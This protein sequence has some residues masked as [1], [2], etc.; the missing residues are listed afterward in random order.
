MPDEIIQGETIEPQVQEPELD[1]AEMNPED[2]DSLL[3]EE[4]TIQPE[5]EKSTEPDVE[6]KEDDQGKAEPGQTEPEIKESEPVKE[7]EK[8]PDQPVKLDKNGNPITGDPLKDTQAELTRSKQE[9]AELKRR[10]LEYEQKLAQL[11]KDQLEAIKPQKELTE[12]ELDDLAVVDPKAY[13]QYL[14]NQER[15]KNQVAQLQQR[16][17]QLAYQRQAEVQSTLRS[18]VSSIIQQGLSFNPETESEKARELAQTPEYQAWDTFVSNNMRFDN[19]GLPVP[20]DKEFLEMSFNHF[21]RNKIGQA[22]QSKSKQQGY[23]EAIRNVQKAATNGSPF[24]RQPTQPQDNPGKRF[25]TVDQDD[26][27]SMTPDELDSALK[28]F[29]IEVTPRKR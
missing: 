9:I 4:G 13:G 6:L 24:D 26:I 28:E 23:V 21:F 14:L 7:P 29:G 19:R 5:G 16:E 25:L 22:D 2:L 15:Y 17:E 12:E 10:Q 27:D 1:L 3:K 20:M 18:N 11:D 8:E